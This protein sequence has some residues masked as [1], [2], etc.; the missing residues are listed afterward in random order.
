VILEKVGLN[1]GLLKSLATD[2]ETGIIGNEADL[3][4][5]QKFFGNNKKKL[6]NV[7]TFF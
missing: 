2:F 7:K 6:P 1:A 3:K 4:R 5:R